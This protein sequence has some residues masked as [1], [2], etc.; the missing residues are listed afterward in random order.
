[1][2]MDLLVIL[3]HDIIVQVWVSLVLRDPSTV[4][5]C[6]LDVA[7]SIFYVLLTE[8]LVAQL[9]Q[10]SLVAIKAFEGALVLIDFALGLRN[11]LI[12]LLDLLLFD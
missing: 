12:K 10:E 1:M 11:P 2:L 9:Q 3:I 4:H 8:F 5:F 7:R 6:A